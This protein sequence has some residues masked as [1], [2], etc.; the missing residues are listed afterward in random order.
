MPID[1]RWVWGGV[2]LGG[3]GL[4]VYMYNR[5][6]KL[7]AQS[8]A[9][10]QQSYGYGFGYGYGGA[11]AYGQTYEPYGYGFGPLGLGAYGGSGLYGYGYYGAGTTGVQTQVPTQATTNAQWSEAAMS[12]LTSAGYDPMTTLA[13]LGQYLLGGN[14]TATQA[15]V[16]TAA[17]GAE[18]YPPQSGPD[19]Y[20]PAMKTGGTPGGGQPPPGTGSGLGNQGAISNLQSYNVTRTSFVAKWNPVPKATG[21]TWAVTQLNG[22]QVKAGS[23]MSRSI[24]VSGLHPGWTYNFAVHANPGGPGDNIHV[25][26]HK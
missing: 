23:S 6:K 8:A 10:S 16:V 24:T 21:Y 12:A 5:D 7:K 11:Y 25:T 1:Q 2:A 19:G 17:I 20:P 13:A 26:T 14:L 4:A 18:G 22:K 3:A 9:A 15:Q